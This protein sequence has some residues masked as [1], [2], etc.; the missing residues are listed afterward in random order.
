[1]ADE[2]TDRDSKSIPDMLTHEMLTP[3]WMKA[4]E[5]RRDEDALLLALVGYIISREKYSRDEQIAA[6]LA[7]RAVID[8]LAPKAEAEERCSFCGRRPPLV[9]IAAGPGAFICD[10]CVSTLSDVFNDDGK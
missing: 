1:M 8:K 2:M 6:L 3:I 5:E 4:F 10:S 9:R 7:L